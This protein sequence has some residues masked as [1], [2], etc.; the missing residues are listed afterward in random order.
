MRGMPDLVVI[1]DPKSEPNA[2]S[3]SKNLG[4]PTIGLTNTNGSPYE[5]DV[6]IPMNN[7]GI[8]STTLILQ[9]LADAACEARNEPTLVSGKPDDQIVLVE[10]KKHDQTARTSHKS[11]M[12][13]PRNFD[14]KPNFVKKPFKKQDGK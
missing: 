2:V 12:N 1:L 7:M 13:S 6:T 3:E 5:T 14:K 11:F 10:E 4:I 8:A 9:I